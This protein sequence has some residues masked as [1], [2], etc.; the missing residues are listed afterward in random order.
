MSRK[1]VI[2]DNDGVLVDSER[3]SHRVL[4]GYL[5]ELGYPMTVEESVHHFLGTAAR[6]VHEVIADKYGGGTLP[7]GF[8][9]LWHERVFE[10]FQRELEATEGAA[11]LLAELND[12][13]I[14][15]CLASSS[16]RSWIDLTL[17]RTGLRGH[18][19]PE[20]VFSAQD[21]GGVGK[22]APD[23][24]LHAAKA[25]GVQPSE[26]LVVE[27][28]PNGVR[29]ACAAGMDVLGFTALTPADRLRDAGATR[30][31]GS[32]SEVLDHR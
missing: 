4:A 3:I 16:D 11:K 20:Q 7:D 24:F 27:D 6:N 26:C 2:F 29:A 9:A 13:G 1:L 28:S 10:A 14:P 18:L 21:V 32:L 22:P 17:E 12:R 23:L 8:V 30:L 31:I 19:R 25:F 15:Y 5:T